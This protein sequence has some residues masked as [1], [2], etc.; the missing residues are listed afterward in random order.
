MR[1]RKDRQD[2]EVITGYTSPSPSSY[3]CA[4]MK[5]KKKKK[6]RNRNGTKTRGK[7]ITKR[8]SREKMMAKEWI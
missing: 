1:W 5:K 4:N 2:I 7:L 8:Y 6:R 3:K